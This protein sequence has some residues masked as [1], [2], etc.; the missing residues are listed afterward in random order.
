MKATGNRIIGTV[1]RTILVCGMLIALSSAAFANDNSE[2]LRDKGVEERNSA[3]EYTIHTGG[4]AVSAS[5]GM[6]FG[7]WSSLGSKLSY[8]ELPEGT[9]LSNGEDG[10]WCYCIDITTGTKDGH[11]YSVTSL[12]AAE[13]YEDSVSAK[14]RSI[15]INSYPHIGVGELETRFGLSELTEEEAFIATQWILWY[16]SNP[17]GLVEAGEEIYYPANIYK[18]SEYPKETMR[19]WYDDKDGNEISV[20]SS[21]VVKLAKALDAL[22]AVEAYETEPINIVVERRTYEDKVIF[23][24]GKTENI[25]ALQN[26]GITV[27]GVN[28]NEV[29]FALS[30]NKIVVMLEDMAMDD[31]GAGLTVEINAEQAL[32]EDVYFFSPE[33]G[34]S[35]SQSRVAVFGGVAPVAFVADFG[36]VRN[37]FRGADAQLKVIKKVLL[38]GEAHKSEGIYYVALFEDEGCT[39]PAFNGDVREIRMRGEVEGTVVFDELVAGKTYYVAETDADGKPL[40]DGDM[41]IAVIAYDKK[42]VTV[43]T[44][45]IAEV[46]ITNCY[47][48]ST[49]SGGGLGDG[50]LGD[51]T[52]EE[53]P[54]D[55]AV[56]TGDNTNIMMLMVM[57]LLLMTLAMIGGVSTLMIGR[58]RA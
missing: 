17:D 42:A 13:Y 10:L 35:A 39:L 6:S 29:P 2:A 31:N 19:I 27:K 45:S 47:E 33:G 12:D 53:K 48:D 11:K 5:A 46:T 51:P 56:D 36:F 9:V 57:M 18:P 8:M 40:K 58:K 22:Q 24:F 38:N 34:R 23:D 52:D 49:E 41:G 44:E 28:G 7:G 43:S 1:F 4:D 54:S 25:E 26:L 55:E 15:L 16:Y 32:K 20:L 3:Y 21:N 50:D 30:G 37:D 14:I